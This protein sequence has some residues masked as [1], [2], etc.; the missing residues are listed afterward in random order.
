MRGPSFPLDCAVGED[1]LP[2]RTALNDPPRFPHRRSGRCEWRSKAPNPISGR[3][4]RPS[5]RSKAHHATQHLAL[6][7]HGR[8]RGAARAN[9]HLPLAGLEARPVRR[10]L[11]RCRCWRPIVSRCAA[12]TPAA[13]LA[14]LLLANA[15][16]S[17]AT[18]R[19]WTGPVTR[20]R[21]PLASS[22]S[23]TPALS[24]GGGDIAPGSR[25]TATGLNAA[26]IC[27][28]SH[29]CWRQRNNWLVWIPAARATSEATAPGSIAAATIRS[30]SARDQ[31]R[32][33]ST[34]AIP[35]PPS[36]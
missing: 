12:L 14:R 30:F 15:F 26:G 22:I 23:I 7:A 3:L 20:I 8:C 17:A 6:F 27:A 31:Y 25:V 2:D 1:Q 36:S 18:V 11:A 24:A 33:R 34:D 5:L 10:R 16:I 4:R 35:Q 32:R 29:S 28:H 9:A 19:A 13:G 21:P